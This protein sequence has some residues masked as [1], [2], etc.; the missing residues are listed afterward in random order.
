MSPL[1]AVQSPPRP[2]DDI[3]AP[4]VYE[5]PPPKQYSLIIRVG[6]TLLTI[7]AVAGLW[8]WVAINPGEVR[9][10]GMVSGLPATLAAIGLV[11]WTW[12]KHDF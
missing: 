9:A 11:R 4:R 10:I 7:A 1:V 12:K 3:P 6:S 8:R 2:W 5:R